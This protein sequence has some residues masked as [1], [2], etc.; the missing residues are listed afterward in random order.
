MIYTLLTVHCTCRRSLLQ[1][2]RSVGSSFGISYI[3][4]GVII[5]QRK[6]FAVVDSSTIIIVMKMLI[7]SWH[8]CFCPFN[9]CLYNIWIVSVTCRLSWT[10][11]TDIPPES[12]QPY[13]PY[14]QTCGW[15]LK[16]MVSTFVDSQITQSEQVFFYIELSLSITCQLDDAKRTSYWRDNKTN[17]ASAGMYAYCVSNGE[18]GGKLDV[19]KRYWET[20][21]PCDVVFRSN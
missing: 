21:W 8:F 12:V 19:F 4:V 20:V 1:S 18:A 5:K 10:S 7:G 2:S 9:V 13:C 6:S 3:G 14:S 17:H 11:W 16:Q 15:T